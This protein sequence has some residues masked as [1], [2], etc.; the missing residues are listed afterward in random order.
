MPACDAAVQQFDGVKALVV[1]RFD[2][3]R[4]EGW[5]MRLPQEDMCQ[6]LGYSPNLKYESDGGPGVVEIMRLLRQ[7]R[8][9]KAD[10]ERFFQS[11]VLFWLLAAIDGHAKNFSLFIEPEGRYRLTPLYDVMSAYPLLAKRQM[12]PRKIK[13]AM[14]LR[15]KNFMTIGA[16]SGLTNGSNHPVGFWVTRSSRLEPAVFCSNPP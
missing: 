8:E 5:I 15:G 4:A 16:S 9:A 11:L 13:M 7:S 14:A 10:R 1:E 12:A 2:R 6:A 3:R